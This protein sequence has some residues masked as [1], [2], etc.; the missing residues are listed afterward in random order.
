MQIV[1]Y[2]AVALL[3]TATLAAC[4]PEIPRTSFTYGETRGR[5]PS[6]DLRFV[7]MPDRTTSLVEVDVRYEVGS[8]EDPPGKAG[9]AHLVEHMMFQHK[10]DGPETQPL[11]HAI[12]ALTT[13][14]NAYTNWDTTHYMMQSRSEQLD[15]LLKIESMRLFFRCKTISED[16]F[17]RE[18]EVVRNEIRQRGG[19][20]EGRI[21]D[22]VL[23]EVYPKSH[24][25]ARMIGG[26]DANLT[27]ITLQDVCDF[28]DKYYTPDRATVIVA[29]G[30]TVEEAAAGIEKWFGPLEKRKGGPRV[31]VAPV[32]SVSRGRAEYELDMERSIVTVSWPLPPS[33]T[34]A[35]RAVQ[36]GINRAIF[37]TF[38]RAQQYEFAYSVDATLL[39]GTEAPVLTVIIELKGIDKLGEALGFVEKAANKAHEGFDDVNWQATEDF[40]A[41]QSASFLQGMEPLYARTTSIGDAVQFDHETE[42]DSTDLYLIKDLERIQ[43]F[44][45]PLIGRETKKALAWNKAKVV[46]F[47]A[48][49]GGIKGDARAKVTFQTKSHDKREIPEVDP[50]E[51]KIPLKVAAEVSVFDTAE[52]YTMNNGMDVVLLPIESP[53]P[54]VAAQLIFEVGDVHSGAVPG[55][56]DRA[57]NFLEPPSNMDA[58]F[59]VGINIAGGTDNDYTVFAASGLDIYLDVVLKGLERT[60]KAGDYDQEGIEAWQ[61]ATRERFRR[62]DYQADVEY[63]RQILTAQYGADHPYTKNGVLSPESASGIGHDRLMDFKGEH[64]SAANATIVVVGKFDT[65]RAKRIISDSFGNWSRGRTDKPIDVPAAPRT[66]PEFIGVV[67]LE[68]PQ[69]TVSISYPAPSGIDGQEAARRVLTEMLNIRMGDI[70]FKLG[71]T[72]GTYAAR[73]PQVGP[74]S[75]QMGGNVDGPRAGESIKAM[76]EGVE[77]LRRGDTFDVDFVRARRA[78]I[79]DLLGQSTVTQQLAAQLGAIARFKVKPDYYKQLIKQIAAASPAQVKML[80]AKELAPAGEVIVC[81]GDRATL[82]KAFADAGIDQVKLVEPDYK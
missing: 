15:A 27:T 31:E 13:F 17:L 46:V 59:R 2:S 68:N 66:G 8:R 80:L 65:G 18:R 69:V 67:G 34:P 39:G 78:L 64:Y 72:Y 70:R 76:R 44:D 1:R 77:M 75:Y 19:T 11:M 3:A 23:G 60:V 26:D 56:A 33:N 61:K 79:E 22:L 40:K 16:E 57:A 29:G 5:L 28:M 74:A 43:K 12:G 35:G 4:N 82:E 24:P 51:A 32:T 25:Y 58:L 73:R 30:V 47:K 53:V 49:Q 42:F 54:L 52:R 41:R 81:L 10:P 14:F 45:G 71:S 20:A 6:N 48:K 38:V 21:P 37:E 36:F 62:K 63:R 9:I 7:I 50:R 55:L